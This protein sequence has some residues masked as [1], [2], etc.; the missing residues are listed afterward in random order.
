MS[1]RPTVAEIRAAFERGERDPVEDADAYG[2][3]GETLTFVHKAVD[4]SVTRVFVPS[5]TSDP[6]V[7]R[8]TDMTVLYGGE[9]VAVLDT[10]T[11]RETTALYLD[12]DPEPTWVFGD[13][14]EVVEG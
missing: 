5:E 11:P 14:V 6:K 10:E 2:S 9:E 8:M 3:D 1:G 4:G 7:R 12:T 13:E